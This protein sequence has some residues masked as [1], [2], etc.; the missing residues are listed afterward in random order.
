M[1]AR[2]KKY[3]PCD[4]CPFSSPPSNFSL[5]FVGLSAPASRRLPELLLGSRL[6]KTQYPQINTQSSSS[7]WTPSLSPGKSSLPVCCYLYRIFKS[8]HILT[9]TSYDFS[10]QL[11]YQ[12]LWFSFF[13]NKKHDAIPNRILVYI[14]DYSEH[15]IKDTYPVLS[16]AFQHQKMK[17]KKLILL[18]QHK[19]TPLLLIGNKLDLIPQRTTTITSRN[20]TTINTAL[21]ADAVAGIGSGNSGALSGGISGVNG[22]SSISGS[23][24]GASAALLSKQTIRSY[25]TGRTSSSLFFPEA[26]SLYDFASD[27]DIHVKDENIYL[28]ITKDDFLEDESL[29][30]LCQ[31]FDFTASR[32]KSAQE[33]PNSYTKM[34]LLERDMGVFLASL[35][36]GEGVLDI[37]QWIL[38]GK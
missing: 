6:P 30:E 35:K 1:T 13:T 34:L 25:Y 16:T 33:V 22:T 7:T 11:R 29:L 31:E 12:D 3:S 28:K 19:Q 24:S 32:F 4:A 38:S 18:S 26:F 5:W 36:T 15:L 21:L 37:I 23:I 10:G 27:F 14:I 20:G 8:V 17:L 9:L 2:D